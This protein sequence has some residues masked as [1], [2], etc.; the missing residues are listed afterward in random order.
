MKNEPISIP[1]SMLELFDAIPSQTSREDRICLL[2]IKEYLL[3]KT[4]EYTYLEI[5]SHLGGTIQPHYADE[6]C[7]MIYSIDK[8]PLIQPDERGQ[9]YQ[10][11]E[12]STERMRQNLRTAFPEATEDRLVTFDT[13]A[14]EVNP[15]QVT[16]APDFCFIDGEHTNAALI[17]DMRFCLSVIRDNAIIC[18]HDSGVVVDGIQV[19]KSELKAGGT[20]FSGMKPGGSVYVFAIGEYA[21]ELR[22]VLN[23]QLTD[24]ETY[25]RSALFHLKRL[26][27]E[28]DLKTK[29]VRL[30]LWRA[31]TGLKDR[32]YL[33]YRSLTSTSA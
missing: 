12:N 19:M 4:G 5:G 27:R 33:L 17:S 28:E 20:D 11:P 10:Y 24:E 18:T 6:R 7:R 15:G 31:A 14:R 29:P 9:D 32:L 1:P 23:D 22:T 21:K 8:R 3:D 25:F 13:D 16:S 30:K 2:S 26:K